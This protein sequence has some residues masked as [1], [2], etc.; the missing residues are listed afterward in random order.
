MGKAS[1]AKKV[2]RAARAG[3]R[4]SSGQ[5]RSL[6]F[7]GILTLIVV[8]GVGLILYAR[9]ERLEEDLGGP[10]Q[11]SDH[12]HQAFGVNVCGEWKPDIPEF[13]S[14]IGIHT[15][16]DGVM[17][18]HPFSQ[19]GAGAN[20]TLGR[21]FQNARDEGGLDVEIS[22][23]KLDFLGDTVEEGETECEGVDEP[24]LRL[25][26]WAKASDTEALPDVITG[27]F[28]DKRL[29]EN[30]A[31]ITVFYGDADAEIPLP[32]TSGNLAE[33]GAADGGS[34]VPD[35][36]GGNTTTSSSV[37]GETT[38]TAAGGTTTTA[39]AGGTTTTTAP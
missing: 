18:I 8:L 28:N 4:V 19:L 17:H 15:H 9:D 1:S 2:Q 25:A 24:E 29:S 32:P 14:Q 26:Y 16:G 22:D 36:E 38:T 33:L 6:L 21:F 12:I 34:T 37:P 23:S 7:P 13:E 39:A 20:A 31:A 30:G 11:I 10:P 5:P 3:G 27:D 35:A